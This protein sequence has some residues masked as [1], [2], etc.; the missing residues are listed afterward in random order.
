[1]KP[2]Y[3]YDV[4]FFVPCYNEEK[5]IEKTLSK[6]ATIGKKL[7]LSYEILIFDDCSKD[8]SAEK[9][10]E[11]AKQ[12]PAIKTRLF[13]NKVNCGL[14]FNYIEGAFHAKGEHYMLINGDNAETPESIEAI[15]SKINQADIIIPYMVDVRAKSRVVIS[16]TFTRLVNLISGHKLNYYNGPVLHKTKNV[17]RWHPITGGY[18]YQAEIL[19]LLLDHKE[20]YLEVQI[21]HIDREEGKSK[22]FKVKNVLSITHS[23]LQIAL[24][25][26]KYLFWPPQALRD[27]AIEQDV[28][29]SSS[30][31]ARTNYN[32]L[33]NAQ[34]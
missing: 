4:S 29:K 9:V 25:K 13:L 12:N 1:M 18:A 8:Q 17:K 7:N 5:V 14:G 11:F 32:E 10:K 21:T 26:F 20:T 33:T 27:M 15:L 31:G 6:L 2:K 16:R 3:E 28:T 24:R 19:C 30:A 22:A 23:L 34:L